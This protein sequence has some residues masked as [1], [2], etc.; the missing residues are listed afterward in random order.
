MIKRYLLIGVVSVA[1][2][3]IVAAIIT[4]NTNTGDLQKTAVLSESTTNITTAV[5]KANNNG[6][7][8]A[9]SNAAKAVLDVQ[10]MSCS[11]CIYQIKS[12]LAGIN[13]IS[14]VLVDLNSGRVEVFYD[15]SQV[16]DLE[17][18]ASAITAV[19]YPATLKQTMTEDEIEKENNL[20]AS[21]SKL[22]IAAVGDWEISRGDFDNELTHARTRYEK[23]YGKNVFTGDQGGALMQRLQS[24]IASSLISEGIQMQEVRK[25]GFKLP[26]KTIAAEFDEYLSE[27]GISRQEFKKVVKDSGYDYGYFY[28]KFENRLTIDQYL[29]DTVLSG[30]SNDL[31]K[32]QQYSDWFNNARLLAKVVYYDKNLENIVK[33]S[34]AGGG[35]CGSSCSAKQ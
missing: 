8:A 9:K 16:K 17:K 26:A 2:L 32:R 6:A 3:L 5:P 28:K 12:G 35:G 19:G 15:R 22:Y 31:E 34:S 25:T 33:N 24:Q 4:A 14:D 29:N 27:K 13:G 18:I 23:A 7:T 11:G 21:R 1:G 20:F 30:L 10:G